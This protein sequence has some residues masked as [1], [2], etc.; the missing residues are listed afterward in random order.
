M[1][2]T[3]LDPSVNL[4]RLPHCHCLNTNSCEPVSWAW[5]TATC[6]FSIHKSNYCCHRLDRSQSSCRGFLDAVEMEGCFQTFQTPAAFSRTDWG[7]ARLA[8]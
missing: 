1:D 6:F 4:T 8:I 3:N 7:L 2:P 5:D